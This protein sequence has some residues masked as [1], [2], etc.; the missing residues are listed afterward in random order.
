MPILSL[1]RTSLRVRGLVVARPL[2]HDAFQHFGNDVMKIGD[3]GRIPVPDQTSD[4]AG[5]ALTNGVPKA[6]PARIPVARGVLEG[7]RAPGTHAATK[8][9]APRIGVEAVVAAATEAA[10]LH[11]ARTDVA[12]LPSA[13]QRVKEI[14]QHAV[15]PGADSSVLVVGYAPF[16]QSAAPSLDPLMEAVSRSLS[17]GH[18]AA[19]SVV[20]MHVPDHLLQPPHAAAFEKLIQSLGQHKVHVVAAR[21]DKAV[22]GDFGSDDAAGPQAPRRVGS[23]LDCALP[24]ASS[25]RNGLPVLSSRKLFR[26]LRSE[27]TDAAMMNKVLVLADPQSTALRDALECKAKRQLPLGGAASHGDDR[28]DA[29]FRPSS[30]PGT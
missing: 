9:A 3:G 30:P 2:W 12:D 28:L 1:A 4:A 29:L 23:V 11:R 7:L 19:G 13:P 16:R 6:G 5:T 18:L 25:L 20:V 24:D 15:R 17:E 22:Y 27:L 14:L 10:A 21:I 26:T 8:H